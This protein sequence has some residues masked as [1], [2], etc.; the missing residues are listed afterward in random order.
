MKSKRF[1]ASGAR[2]STKTSSCAGSSPDRGLCAR[3]RQHVVDVILFGTG[4][5]AERAWR[6]IS[7][8]DD[9]NVVCF[10]DN[11]VRK[12]GQQF[13]DRPIIGPERPGETSWDYV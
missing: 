3:W 9:I 7:E 11:D 5:N 2:S 10:A 13:H 4:S 1:V 12:H 6:A 8:R